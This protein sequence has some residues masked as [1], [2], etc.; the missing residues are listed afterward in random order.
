MNEA[1]VTRMIERLKWAADA[2]HRRH[3]PAQLCNCGFERTM[4]QVVADAADIIETQARE[5]TDYR[6][7]TAHRWRRERS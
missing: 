4:R 5:F 6:A 2:G 7:A 3:C 1:L